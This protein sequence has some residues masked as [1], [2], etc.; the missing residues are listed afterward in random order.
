MRHAL[1]LT[2][3]VAMS[4]TLAAQAPPLSDYVGTYTDRPGHT[5]EIVAGDQLFAVQ[6]SAK[7]KLQSSKPDEFITIT[8]NKIPFI[9]DASGK[10]IGYEEDGKLHPRVSLSITPESA[11]LARPWPLSKGTTYHYHPPANLHDGI[12]VASITHSDLGEATA[13]AIV[14]SILNGTYQ[15]VHS[16]LLYQHGHLV[17]EE[18]FYGYNA[19]RQHQLRSA[20]KSVV[21]AV[22]GIA[23]D[24]GALTGANELVLPHMSYTTYANPDPRKSKI[25]LGN[26]LSMS[27]GLDCND[28]SGTSP[29][30]ETVLDDAPDWVKATLDLPMIND[31]GSKGF[32]CSGGVAV[33][34]RMA[35]N[36]THMYLPDFAQKNLFAPL[37]IPR[38]NWTWNYNLT[39]ANKE[40]SQI[41]LRP[42]DMLKLG[43]LFADGG[44]WK[45][46]QVISSS[47][48]QASLTT[49]SQIDG[50]DYGYFWWKPYFNVPT[51]NGIQRVHFSAAQGNGGQ[52]IYLLP[53]YDL[54][55]VF[56]A[57]DYNSGG[58][59]PNKIMI[60]II[61][62]ALIAARS[63][64]K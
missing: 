55:A 53:Q 54:V 44:K 13:D 26:F 8:G 15:D 23:I 19:T 22:V 51:P 18:Y 64:V 16:V 41:H 47:W 37:G 62:P 52:K 14:N 46:H 60:N 36:A 32:Y 17:M 48:V 31:P 3:L 20:T 34:G 38:T 6:D 56:T 43:I 39:N 63:H 28:H 27:S 4:S 42:R 33:A 45:G 30:R 24:R 21:S 7:Y 61:L 5:L 11:A 59:P 2:L 50:T 40:Y 29:G 25:T 10:V 35:E 1:L 58:A 12:A 57:G 49:Q 9:R